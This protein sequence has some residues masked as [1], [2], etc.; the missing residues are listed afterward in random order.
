MS[1]Q[2]VMQDDI[3]QGFVDPYAAV[4][5]DV[6]E[7]SEAVHEEADAGTGGSDDLRQRF[8]GYGGNE[9]LRFARLAEIGHK[10][11]GAGQTPLAGV[12]Q[13]IDEIRLG[14]NAPVEHEVQEE[15]GEILLFVQGFK[16]LGAGDSER[17][18]DRYRGSAGGA[19]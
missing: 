12:E 15:G 17:H 14:A 19:E 5:F 18:A 2:L 4:V 11:E 3:Q 1:W 8:L 9:A 16:H 10:Q 6:A 7:L 13:L